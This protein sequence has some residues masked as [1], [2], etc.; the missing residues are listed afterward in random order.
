MTNSVGKVHF[1]HELVQFIVHKF[2]NEQVQF[3][4][5]NS[6]CLTKFTA[7][8]MS[9]NML[10]AIIEISICLQHRSWP[11]SSSAL[12]HLPG[13]GLKRSGATLMTKTF[14]KNRTFYVYVS[15]MQCFQPAAN[16]PPLC[17]PT[18]N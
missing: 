7:P 15:G 2:K 4:V 3:I 18:H 9:F 14:K 6:K 17:N 11:L 16:F 13:I 1:L 10:Q 12:S 5:Y 8:K